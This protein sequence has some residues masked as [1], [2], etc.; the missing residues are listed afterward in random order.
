[1]CSIED[2]I[3]NSD[4]ENGINRNMGKSASAHFTSI[5]LEIDFYAKQFDWPWPDTSINKQK[6]Y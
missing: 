6:I 5:W 4:L 1:M 3:R 2:F